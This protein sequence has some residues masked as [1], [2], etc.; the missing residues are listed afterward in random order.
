MGFQSRPREFKGTFQAGQISAAGAGRGDTH[1]DQY[2]RA[3]SHGNCS[4]NCFHEF[5]LSAAG[6]I[7]VHSEKRNP[8]EKTRII[9]E[10]IFGGNSRVSG[11]TFATSAVAFRL[12]RLAPQ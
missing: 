11:E 2:P 7:R 5:P 12:S 4:R 3:E 9:E 8:C 1:R 6:R 10:N